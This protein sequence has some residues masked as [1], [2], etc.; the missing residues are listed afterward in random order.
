M[1]KKV[2]KVLMLAALLVVLAL[3]LT[4]CGDFS[5]LYVGE[6]FRVPGDTDAGTMICILGKCWGW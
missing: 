5:T 4:A 3:V 1:N 6:G 2:V